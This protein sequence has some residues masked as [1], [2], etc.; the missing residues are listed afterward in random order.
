[1]TYRA[2]CLATLLSLYASSVLA[3]SER[4]PLKFKDLSPDPACDCYEVRFGGYDLTIPASEVTA[5]TSITLVVKNRSDKPYKQT[6]DINTKK[7]PDSIQGISVTVPPPLISTEDVTR[8]ACEGGGHIGQLHFSVFDHRYS[9]YGDQVRASRVPS[10]TAHYYTQLFE[11]LLWS[12]F[13][14]AREKWSELCGSDFSISPLGAVPVLLVHGYVIDSNFLDA[15][16]K[17]GGGEDT[18]GDLPEILEQQ[19]T[20]DGRPIVVYEF[21]WGSNSRLQDTA[22]DLKSAVEYI[23]AQTGNEVN[24]V[25]HS[26]GGLLARTYLQGLIEI[27]SPPPV[28][29]LVTIGTPHSGIARNGEAG[30][31][32]GATPIVAACNQISCY[33]A[34]EPGGAPPFLLYPEVSIGEV[35]NMIQ[36][37]DA[38]TG[39]PQYDFRASIDI[40]VLIGAARSGLLFTNDDFLITIAGQRWNA[41]G[42]GLF[43]RDSSFGSASISEYLLQDDE[44]VFVADGESTP[45]GFNG[46]VHADSIIFETDPQQNYEVKVSREGRLFCV[47]GLLCG[48]DHPTVAHVLDALNY[49]DTA[50][51]FELQ[52]VVGDWPGVRTGNR[53]EQFFTGVSGVPRSVTVYVREFSGF[54]SLTQPSAYRIDSLAICDEPDINS[55]CT[56]YTDSNGPVTFHQ[57]D[58]NGAQVTY[59]FPESLAVQLE[60]DKYFK[61]GLARATIESQ[62]LEAGGTLTNPIPYSDMQALSGETPPGGFDLF[63]II[64][65][66]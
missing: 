22:R 64:E 66:D 29:S 6:L 31:P 57:A 16:P 35:V 12:K 19:V 25:A 46:Y 51:R 53:I 27:D 10:G 60:P 52:T 40:S 13:K 45:L 43:L 14:V 48:T 30:L 7:I 58:G 50:G 9:K 3:A 4:L 49:N 42:A 20:A 59:E 61:V 33:Q 39:D 56:I 5:D 47:S 55:N 15:T 28:R 54:P 41:A 36:A 1:M 26:F 63:Y 44:A 65:T 62:I 18:W 24:V 11:G 37:R 23:Y 32:L 21:R 2:L 17:T 8:D 38:S 34:G